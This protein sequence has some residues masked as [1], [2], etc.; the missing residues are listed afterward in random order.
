MLTFYGCSKFLRC[1]LKLFFCS[2]WWIRSWL[3]RNST[4]FLCNIGYKTCLILNFNMYWHSSL[5]HLILCIY[6]TLRISSIHCIVHHPSTYNSQ[7][8]WVFTLTSLLLGINVL[9][10]LRLLYC[11]EWT[12]ISFNWTSST[13]LWNLVIWPQSHVQHTTAGISN[14]SILR[15]HCFFHLWYIAWY[16]SILTKS[17]SKLTLSLIILVIG[18]L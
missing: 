9:V 8:T 18:L 4:K 14:N 15:I 1:L 12:L 6:Q 5:L 7:C 10:I 3:L 16:I 11:A 2:C 13:H 17:R